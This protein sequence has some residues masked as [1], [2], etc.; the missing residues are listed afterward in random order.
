MEK[1]LI[2]ACLV[3]DKTRYDG[4]HNL[5]PSI[6][7]LLEKY[8]LVPFCPEVEGGLPTPRNPSEI[9]GDKV[10]MD[11]GHDVT[12]NF[13]EGAIKALMLCQFLKIKIAVLKERSPSCGTHQVHDGSFKNK[14]IEGMG[15]TAK[16][17]KENNIDVYSEDEIDKLL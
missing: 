3:G 5:N 14:L 12:D 15:I 2:S 9:K 4:K 11:N 10:I 1:I 6:S 13:K 7:Q 17:L 16:L 8:E